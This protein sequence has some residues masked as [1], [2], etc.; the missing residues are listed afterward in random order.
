[1]ANSNTSTHLEF[2]KPIG[3]Q[4]IGG[5]KRA[6]ATLL[7]IPVGQINLFVNQRTGSLNL[8]GLQVTPQQAL[9]IEEV[10]S[11]YG[12]TTNFNFQEN[13]DP[14]SGCFFT[15]R[16]A[17]EVL[18]DWNL[19]EDSL[20][21][22]IF[23]LLFYTVQG[24]PNEQVGLM[25]PSFGLRINGNNSRLTKE[26]VDF[27]TPGKTQDYR[28]GFAVISDSSTSTLFCFPQTSVFRAYASQNELEEDLS[29]KLPEISSLRYKPQI[30]RPF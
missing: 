29:E 1:M 20:P 25:L 24:L 13:F 11:P 10:F 21:P 27:L 16:R 9:G 8:G 28:S 4:D 12:P 19:G 17:S 7:Q 26:L 5:I 15:E 18:T 14:Y 23:P 2:K 30:I 22:K 3:K 6:L